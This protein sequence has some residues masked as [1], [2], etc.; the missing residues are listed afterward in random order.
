MK[1]SR[2]QS[3]KLTLRYKRSGIGLTIADDGMGF[4]TASNGAPGHYGLMGMRERAR[5]I[6]AEFAIET[7]QGRGTTVRVAVPLSQ[8]PASRRTAMGPAR[9]AGD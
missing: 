3:L 7:G 9:A 4:D 6:G 5:E 2:A 1:H 8:G